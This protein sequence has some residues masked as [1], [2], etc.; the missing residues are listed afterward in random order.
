MSNVLQAIK[1]LICNPILDLSYHY[2]GKNRANS[3]GNSLEQYTKDL[4]ASTLDIKDEYLKI[5]KYSDV[6]SYQGN[7]NNPPDIILKNGDCIEVKKIQGSTNSA[8]AL[9]SS[10]P[11]AKL[12]SDSPMI[13]NDCKKCEIWQEK[14]LIYV[15]GNVNDNK[16]KT[17]WFVYGD[18]YAADKSVYERIRNTVS[19]GLEQ[20]SDV[21]FAK[22]NEIGKV[23][24]VDPLGITDLRIRGMWSVFH[25]ARVFSYLPKKKTNSEFDFY[26]IMKKEKFD[27]FPDCDKNELF[28]LKNEMFKM[29]DLKIKNPNNP[30]S[31]LDVKFMEFYYG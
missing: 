14:D 28:K 15:V 12:Y 22:T 23:K 3:M 11:K 25:P 9:N 4:F 21:E 1:N 7:Q 30:A 31:L 27:E 8:L 2:S 10:Y 13:T 20:I 5:K 18:C 17:L 24:K 16:L 19:K 29:S 26:C 6:F